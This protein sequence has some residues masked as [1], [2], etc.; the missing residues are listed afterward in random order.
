MCYVHCQSVPDFRHCQRAVAPLDWSRVDSTADI[1][2]PHHRLHLSPSYT[3][4]DLSASEIER[5]VYP[6]VASP[7]VHTPDGRMRAVS[8]RLFLP[9]GVSER[10]TQF[11]A[12]FDLR[13]AV[14]IGILIRYVTAHPFLRNTGE[15]IGEVA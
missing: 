4:G 2:V 15:L 9:L 3:P 5:L 8:W 13:A 6:G 14:V 10:A 11:G 12:F 7:L 1:A